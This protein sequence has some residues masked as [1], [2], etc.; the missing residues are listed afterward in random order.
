VHKSKAG[1]Q[2]EEMNEINPTGGKEYLN[3]G[4]YRKSLRFLFIAFM[5]S[6]GNVG[7]FQLTNTLFEGF[8]AGWI[9]V[10]AS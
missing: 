4:R 6:W 10:C 8:Y 2:P 1:R 9:L 3:E 5:K 7:E